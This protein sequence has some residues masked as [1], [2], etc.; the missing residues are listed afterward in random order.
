MGM[1]FPIVLAAP[2]GSA[3]DIILN[4]KVGLW[5]PPEDPTALANAI[6]QLYH[7]PDLLH[8]LAEASRIAASHHTRE[9]QSRK[10]LLALESLFLP[11]NATPLA[12]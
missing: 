6:L 2:K 8:Q 5:V 4:E 10:F 11:F 9:T 1:G 12:G 3:R 7:H